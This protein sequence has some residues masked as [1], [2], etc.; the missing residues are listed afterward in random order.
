MIFIKNLSIMSKYYFLKVMTAAAMVFVPFVAS[1]QLPA[2]STA[3]PI[4]IKS[5]TKSV[6][7][8][9]VKQVQQ[10]QSR[11]KVADVSAFYG[12]TLY[13]T[14]LSSSEWENASI[15]S[16][17]Y[18][19]YSFEMGDAPSPKAHLTHLYYSFMSG[20]NCRGKFYGIT[21]LSAMGVFNGS[22]Y[23]T[24]DTKK[25]KE[26]SSQYHSTDEA[27]YSLLAAVMGYNP[28]DNQIYAFQYNDDLSGLYWSKYNKETNALE[29]I[30]SFR[31]QYN[32]LTLASDPSGVLYFINDAGDLYTIN[33]A[34]GRATLKGNT[35]ITPTLYSQ[36]MIYDGKTGTFLWTSQTAEGSILYSVDPATAE[37][38]EI[39]KFQNNEQFSSLYSED[40]DAVSDAPA[41]VK[42]LKLTYDGDGALTGNITFTVPTTTYGGAI[43]DSGTLNVWLDGVNQKGVAASA[44]DK[45]TMPVSLTDGNHYIAVNMKNESGF[46]PMSTV[47][48]YAGYD[49]P[50]KSSSVKFV[51]NKSVGKD[52]VTWLTPDSGVNSGYID[53]AN[54]KYNIVRMPDSVTVATNYTMNSYIEDIPTAMHNYS[55]RVYAINKDKT[56]AY[57]ESN[58]IISGNSFTIPYSQDFTKTTTLKDFFTVVDNNKDNNTWRNGYNNEVRIGIS[59]YTGNGDDWLITPAITLTKGNKYR[60]SVSLKTYAAGYP[61]N[62]KVYVGTNPN[63]ISTFQLIDDEEKYECYKDYANHNSDF[64]VD[65]DG[66]YYVALYYCGD[67]LQKSSLLMIKSVSV[68]KIGAVLAPESVSDL[69]ITPDVNDDLAATVS[70][71]SPS[72]DLAGNQL[73]SISNIKVYR[74]NETNAAYT[75]E[76]PAVGVKLSWN[77]TNVPAVGTNSYT[78]V[79]SNSN[80]EGEKKSASA[81]IGVYTAPYCEKFNTAATASLYTTEYKGLQTGGNYGWAYQNQAMAL[82]AFVM[83]DSITNVWLFTPAIKMDAEA[84]YS[85][86]CLANVNVYTN[87]IT[88]K[89]YAGNAADSASQTMFLGDMP[90]STNYKYQTLSYNMITSNAGKYYVGIN[91]IGRK[92]WDY[93]SMNMDSMTVT[94]LKSAKSP[95]IITDYKSQADATGAFKATLTFKAPSID[96]RGQVL[97]ELSKIDIYRGESAIP[98]ATINNPTPGEVQTW[99]DNQAIHGINKY[100]IVPSNSYGR[101]EAYYDTIYVGRDIPEAVGNYVLKSTTDNADAV[102]TWNAPAKGKNGGVVVPSELSYNIYKY[103]TSTQTFATVASNITDCS[104][105]AQHSANTTQAVYYYAVTPINT[106]GVGDTTVHSIVLGKLYEMPYKESFAKDSLSTS[107]WLIKTDNSYSLTWGVTNPDGSTYNSALAEDSDGGCAYM[108][109]GSYSSYYGGA[110]FISPKMTLN[111]KEEILSF[112]IY[113]IKTG[114]TNASAKKPVI[115]VKASVDDD[116]FVQLGDTIIVGGDTEDGWRHYTISLD[117]YKDSKYIC[118]M[119]NG[120]T[121][122]Y[123]DVIYLDTIVVGNAIETSI[124]NTEKDMMGIKSINYYDLSGKMITNPGKGIYIKAVTF[125]DGTKKY[126]KYINK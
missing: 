86:S 10:R 67:T 57:T 110:G 124:N 93:M 43:F 96:Y 58:S 45:I 100:M 66:D 17:P 47:Y 46:S 18:G 1:A 102:L 31:G 64:S 68:N 69:T 95:Y 25:W 107:P 13:G 80:G 75:F 87:T 103:D 42:D 41:S 76:N 55:Y 117:K 24:L 8:F 116:D 90:K 82:N 77:D 63:D 11:K 23:I 2:T 85:V 38:T 62:F 29:Q 26:I 20:A 36:A 19:I 60:Y 51:S 89:V 61:E 37:T 52:T 84:V 14:M 114:Y 9:I 5:V 120:F 94:Y 126:I 65:K 122:G 33:K 40:N 92:Q 50:V 44:G 83:G 105:T 4:P 101:G 123:S 54:L 119:F 34:T 109:N 113:N 73:S 16:V 74:N 32:V 39:M 115:V 104:F 3:G 79:G 118:F 56:G 21:A 59:K 98:I 91:S 30:A 72:K 15:A 7:N 125:G 27:S 81:F 111:G 88:N 97:S 12:R 78:V 108:Y 22:R 70:F 49:T 121:N 35:G 53:K 48:Q 28:T 71:T 106:E 99:T 6:K 112:W